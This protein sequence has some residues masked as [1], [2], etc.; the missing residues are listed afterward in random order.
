MRVAL[1]ALAVVVAP[2]PLAAGGDE[3][4]DAPRPPAPTAP[5][6]GGTAVPAGTWRD[7]AAILF[8]GSQGCSGVLVAPTVVL[9]AD[10][11]VDPTL[12]AVLLG[13]HN[14]RRPSDGERIA[15]IA[16]HRAPSA[17]DLAALVLARPSTIPPRRLATGWVADD[18]VDGAP[19]TMVGFGAI[20]RDATEFVDELQ[21]ASSTIT[22]VGCTRSAGCEAT[23]RP[24]GELGAG[25]GGID[26]CPGDSG[27]PLYLTGPHGAFLV[28]ITSRGYDD[29][30][31][32]C[33][34]GGIYVRPDKAEL[35]AWVEA[36]TG[37]FLEDGL[38]PSGE[39][40]TIAP[41]ATATQ[42]LSAD[43]PD[44]SA[45]RWEIAAAPTRGQATIAADGTLTV[46]AP[47][48]EGDDAV[49]V[50][51]IDAADPTRSARV[52][53]ALTY[54]VPDDGGCCGGAQSPGGPLALTAVAALV[55]ARRRRP[56]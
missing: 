38:H 34:E 9:T 3:V 4:A 33:S 30:Q 11:C 18:V 29:S 50:R 46:L 23:L 15:V 24:A 12:D 40:M 43:D 39:A 25:G 20:D 7:A 56:R 45:H 51:A 54:G 5:V 8:D 6:I 22:D 28:G 41:G 17:Y 21:Q 26:T 31:Y 55:L 53:I 47:A 1:V 14:L 19:V 13:V 27:G 10:H 2:A 49:V 42:V 35:V 16:Q 36:Q 48:E 37:V 52:R 32:D 44:A